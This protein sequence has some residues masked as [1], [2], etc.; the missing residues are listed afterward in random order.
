MSYC[1][2]MEPRIASILGRTHKR[3]PWLDQLNRVTVGC[4]WLLPQWVLSVPSRILKEGPVNNLVDSALGKVYGS[5]DLL[6]SCF[7]LRWIS[8]CSFVSTEG[9]MEM[10]TGIFAFHLPEGLWVLCVGSDYWWNIHKFW[11]C[12]LVLV[13]LSQLVHLC[14]FPIS[15]VESLRSWLYFFLDGAEIQ[16]FCDSSHCCLL[17]YLSLANVLV[18]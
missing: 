9:L 7:V 1:V 14:Q 10:H 16:C 11:L 17:V 15:W 8:L 2:A 13:S 12:I 3:V 5:V 4:G 18:D 6:Q